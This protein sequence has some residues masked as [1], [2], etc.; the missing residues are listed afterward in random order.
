MKTTLTIAKTYRLLQS[1][2]P[3]NKGFDEPPKPVIETV[4]ARLTVARNIWVLR[5]ALEP[6]EEKI[7]KERDRLTEGLDPAELESGLPLNVRRQLE[8]F[9]REVNAQTIVVEL[10]PLAPT[11][12]AQ[13][14][15]DGEAAISAPSIIDGLICRGE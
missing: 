11:D 1:L 10:T 6:A 3:I 2:T 12:L 8:V 15:F 7:T 13:D 4:P 9:S 14:R 5:S